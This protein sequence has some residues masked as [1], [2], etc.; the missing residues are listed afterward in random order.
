MGAMSPRSERLFS[1]T[2]D[3]KARPI[4]KLMIDDKLSQSGSAG[5]R[6]QCGDR[7]RS[8]CTVFNNVKARHTA[9]QGK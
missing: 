8:M 7:W 4:Q 1:L 2:I 5:K 9:T 3:L 6:G